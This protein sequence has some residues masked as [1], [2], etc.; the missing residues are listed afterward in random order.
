[1]RRITRLERSIDRIL[2]L[3]G[4]SRL[5]S[6]VCLA[7]RRRTLSIAPRATF[8]TSRVQRKSE[9]D[10]LAFTERLR[11]KIWGTS[12]PPGQKDPYRKLS[13]EEQAAEEQEAEE[14]AER[15]AE[16]RRGQ[17]ASAEN[18]IPS[19]DKYEPATTWDGLESVGGW[20]DNWDREHTFRGFLSDRKMA[21]KYAITATLHRAVVEVLLLHGEGRPYANAT[22]APRDDMLTG[23]TAKVQI[24]KGVD[25]DNLRYQNFILDFPKG[26]G[27]SEAILLSMLPNEPSEEEEVT[28]EGEDA[29]EDA[30]DFDN[31]GA[32]P[33]DLSNEE[34]PEINRG[35][36]DWLHL[37]L[38][39]DD[40]IK[41]AVIKRVMQLTG[42]HI[43]DVKIQGITTVNSLLNTLIKP[44]KPKKLLDAL[45]ENEDLASLPNVKIFDRRITPIDREKS[46]GRWKVIERE[47]ERRELPV[48]GR[49]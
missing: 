23:K 28:E 32:A 10:Q 35:N 40:E 45:V 4:S 7:C 11:R 14:R 48:T 18:E 37:S 13:P 46:V 42:I 39:G 12:E 33:L 8:S 17:L 3:A 41:F 20:D 15:R 43:P 27:L 22:N 36:P 44:P 16:R 21:D 38:E 47:L 19:A 6:S 31:E 24:T 9:G 30:E 34:R 26:E 49:P 1:M 5:P 25:L 29:I 2:D